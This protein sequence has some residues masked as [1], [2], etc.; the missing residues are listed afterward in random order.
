MIFIILHID[1]L[2]CTQDKNKNE[3]DD[4]QKDTSKNV[5]TNSD[6]EKQVL[7]QTEPEPLAESKEEIS[8]IKREDGLAPQPGDGKF[9]PISIVQIIPMCLDT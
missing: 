9:A 2:H 8:K 7:V 1:S 4:S 5:C 6:C 3:K